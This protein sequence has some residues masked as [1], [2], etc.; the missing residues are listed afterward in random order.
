M[1][2]AFPRTSTNGHDE[3]GFRQIAE[4]LPH[5]TWTCRPD[6]WCDYLSPQWVAYA[7]GAEGDY[8][9]FNWSL[10]VHPDDRQRLLDAWTA[11]VKASSPYNVEYRIHRNDGV[12][13]WFQ[14][15]AAPV[16]NTS[17]KILK[18]FG[19][20]TDVDDMKNIENA[21]RESERRKDEFL[22]TL[23]HELR[24]PLAP[25]RNSLH[26]LK[27]YCKGNNLAVPVIQ[28]MERQIKLI[29]R[30][31]DDLL[32]LSRINHGTLILR[33]ERVELAT[34]VESA[35]ET[36]HSLMEAA[37]H[38]FILSL[39][40]KPLWLDCDSVRVS[41]VLANL[42]NN[43]AK[44]TNHGGKISL[45]ARKQHDA[46]LISVRDNGIGLSPDSIASMF[47][48][49]ARVDTAEARHRNGLGIGLA[50]ARRL[51]EMHGGTI[52]ATSNG[53]GKGSEF[54]VRLPCDH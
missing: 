4:S 11:A 42:L 23:S 8:H 18:W 33:R 50:L 21:L 7:G 17:G 48:M 12:Y 28:M 10:A 38:Q 47:D 54:I 51:T 13:R 39:P 20:S 29:V 37:G 44:Y 41:Q 25:V 52:N 6:G 2:P 46:V 3:I 45:Q 53:P 14:G 22:S 36:T 24:N 32:D 43:A 9:G 35:V 15:H 30:L 34:V 40:E 1:Q 19:T 27:E 49:F 16:K 5:L 26:L 31:V